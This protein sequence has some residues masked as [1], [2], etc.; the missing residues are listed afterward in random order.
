LAFVE[1][2][3]AHE[4]GR[5]RIVDIATGETRVAGRGDVVDWLDDDTLLVA[6]HGA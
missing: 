3:P 4:G 6:T 1:E 2:D 5:I